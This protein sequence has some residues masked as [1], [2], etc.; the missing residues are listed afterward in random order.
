MGHQIISQLTPNES[1]LLTRGVH[2]GLPLYFD[3]LNSIWCRLAIERHNRF[4]VCFVSLPA[5]PAIKVYGFED[6]EPIENIM[7]ITAKRKIM[8]KLQVN[9]VVFNDHVEI[10]CQIPI[11]AERSVNVILNL[12]IPLFSKERHCTKFL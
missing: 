2:L 11:E 4:I 10:R 3:E 9:L 1:D 5:K 12:E 7:S 8:D 6:I